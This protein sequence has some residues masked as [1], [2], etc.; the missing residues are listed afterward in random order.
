MNNASL[1]L[2]GTNW[3]EKDASLLGYTV[4]DDSGR[5]F[6]QEFTF[7]RGSNLAATRIGKTGLIEKGRENLLLQSNQFDTTWTVAGSTITDGQSGYDGSNNAWLLSKSSASGNLGQN[8][9]SNG[10][11]TF[12]VYAKA[13]ASLYLRLIIFDGT[14]AAN[15]AA[16]FDLQ[17]GALGTTN[18]I[19]SNIESVGN[20]WYRCS[21]SFNT[22]NQRVYIY[23]AEANS[24]TGTT[25]SIYIQDAQLEL[26]LSASPYIPTTTTTAQA[27]V[28]ENTPRLN[29]TTG[30]ANPSLLLEPS[31]TNLIRYSE[32]IDGLLKGGNPTLSI[33]SETNPSGNAFAYKVTATATNSRIQD[34]L[35]PKGNN[36]VFSGFFKGTGT[37]TRIYFVNN[38]GEGVYYDID[39]N[40]TF[41][42]YSEDIVN[43]NYGIDDYG[44][45]WHR[46]YFETTTSS[47]SANY[48]QVFA[49]ALDG[50]GSVFIWGL[51]AEQGSYPTSYIPTYS[52]QS[53]TR[54]QDV[55]IKTD[56]TGEI[57]STEGVLF[58]EGK[59]EE[60]DSFAVS[61][62]S[63][64]DGTDSNRLSILQYRSSPLIR[65]SMNVGGA[66]QFDMQIGAQTRGLYYKIAA[67]Y[68][69][70]NCSLF[71]N[72]VKIGN[73]TSATMP[74]PNTFNK[75]GFVI[76]ADQYNYQGNVKQVLLY[77]TALTD[78]EVIT[79]TTP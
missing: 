47:V 51:Q 7:S 22:S 13:N 43:D 32:Y 3:A 56:A 5:F 27:G 18:A 36:F 79:L 70:N 78:A 73:D 61:T 30:V 31:R 57:N 1:E 77:P 48:I 12:S 49:D 60:E 17:N 63:I 40:G 54:A 75:I 67:V 41:T 42:L 50:D 52:G 26:G 58:I 64:S 25:G 71:I 66:T 24:T 4:S 46:I 8:T 55:C 39:T 72:G 6:P 2:G 21:V 62:L 68:S 44:N 29:Y 14:F 33:E 28:L 69:E 11:T 20:G 35:G 19:D 59:V 38:Q 9:T 34:S 37:A 10:V 16:Y 74:S 76:A 45:G 53:A 15:G 65:A 23:P